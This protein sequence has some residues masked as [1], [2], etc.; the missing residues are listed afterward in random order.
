MQQEI[1]FDVIR[2]IIRVAKIM[3]A[4]RLVNT[5]EGNLSV[6]DNGLIY[7]TPTNTRK[8]TLT[9]D[10][11]AVLDENG[12]QVF[13]KRKPSSEIIMH[14]AA[15]K[16]REDA[17]AVIH[18]H[19]PYLTAHAICNIPIDQKCHPEMMMHYRDIPVAPYGRPG[20]SEIIDNAASYIKERNLV[21][22]GNHGVL[23]V[24]S[25]LELTYQ[26]VEAAEKFA[27]ILA[28][29]R[30]LGP[31][32]DIPQADIDFLMNMDIEV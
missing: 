13:G 27:Q 21:L 16:L 8:S 14:T 10:L 11:I 20:T 19:S 5:Y 17:N 9:E 23:A 18:C 3:E 4:A 30:G 1:N 26:R 12:N 28:I 29:A 25:T 24:G 7:I 31:T 6:K 15:Y 32:V 22:L 2:E